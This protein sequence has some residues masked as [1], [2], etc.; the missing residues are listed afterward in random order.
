[1]LDMFSKMEQQ[2]TLKDIVIDKYHCIDMWEHDL[3]PAYGNLGSL[4]QLK[5]PVVVMTGTCTSRTEEVILKSLNLSN[6]TAVRQSWDRE[7]I[8]LFVKK[9]GWQ[10]S[11]YSLNFGELYWSM[12]VWLLFKW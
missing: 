7:N 5:C 11:G 9:S 1:M 2:S 10:G 12:W 8:S 3:R 6:V 4:T